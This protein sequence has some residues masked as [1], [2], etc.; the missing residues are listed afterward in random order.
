MIVD[1]V[2]EQIRQNNQYPQQT[3]TTNSSPLQSQ[4]SEGSSNVNL[5]VSQ[6][7]LSRAGLTECSEEEN[8]DS[9]QEHF[10][11]EGTITDTNGD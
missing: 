8:E 10:D 3:T 6:L 2:T 7:N 1:P 4:E 9:E 11:L 5:H